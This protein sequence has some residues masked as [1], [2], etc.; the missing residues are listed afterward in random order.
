MDRIL[1]SDGKVWENALLVSELYGV[2]DDSGQAVILGFDRDE[3]G[4]FYAPLATLG[5]SGSHVRAVAL[6]IA[7]AVDSERIGETEADIR[8]AYTVWYDRRFQAPYAERCTEHGA[9]R[10]EIAAMQVLRSYL[11]A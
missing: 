11:G 5:K 7:R 10:E 3:H 1:R 2:A 8:R 6:E 4:P 9:A